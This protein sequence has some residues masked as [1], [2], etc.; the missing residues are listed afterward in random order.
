MA[1]VAKTP[2]QA[3]PVEVFED[4]DTALA[5]QSHCITKR[6]HL[7]DRVSLGQLH[8]HSRHSPDHRI[9]VEQVADHLMQQPQPGHFA[10]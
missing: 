1:P 8:Q 5:P 6:R 9:G 10:Q 7:D 3:E 4:L 2:G